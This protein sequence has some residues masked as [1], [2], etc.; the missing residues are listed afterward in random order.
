MIKQSSS[1]QIHKET[2]RENANINNK[3]YSC[4][5]LRAQLIDSQPMLVPVEELAGRW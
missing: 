5:L 4:D 2:C 3:L 1:N